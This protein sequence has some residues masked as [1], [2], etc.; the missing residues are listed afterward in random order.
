MSKRAEWC[1]NARPFV[2]ARAD[3]EVCPGPLLLHER[4]VF[5]PA[6]E[7]VLD[8]VLG[9][10]RLAADLAHDVVHRLVVD[11]RRIAPAIFHRRLDAHGVADALGDALDALGHA[12]AD[13]GIERA[14][15]P[16]QH[17]FVGNDVER[18][19]GFNVAD[20]DDDGIFAARSRG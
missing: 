10:E 4:H 2:A 6:D 19:A 14:H 9:A 20:G 15:R 5:G 16:A 3:D 18:R 8:D 1:G 13:L 17:H 7:I 11:R 12:L